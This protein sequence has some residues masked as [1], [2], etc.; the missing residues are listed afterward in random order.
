V[1]GEEAADTL[2]LT[3]SERRRGLRCR[4]HGVH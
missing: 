4:R 1:V 2:P 3:P